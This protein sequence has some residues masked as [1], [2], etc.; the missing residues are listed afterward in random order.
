[1]VFKLVRIDSPSP[2]KIPLAIGTHV[3]GR[4]KFLHNDDTDKRVSRNHAELEVTT[5]SVNLK[6]LHQNPCF[7]IKKS[8]ETHLLQQDS[9]VLLCHGDKFGLLPDHFWYEVLHCPDP[10]TPSP[11]TPD[12]TD[13]DIHNGEEA[14]INWNE[15]VEEQDNV[16]PENGSTAEEEVLRFS[17]EQP[18][19]FEQ[20]SE[21]VNGTRSASPSLLIAPEPDQPTDV[22]TTSN[23][24]DIA[25]P[26]PDL[27][28]STDTEDYKVPINLPAVGT[29]SPAKRDHSPNDTSPV[30]LKRVKNERVSDGDAAGPS[31]DQPSSN[32]DTKPNVA[33]PAQPKPRLRERCL[34][35]ENCY[36]RNPQHLSEFSHPRDADWGAGSRGTCPYGAACRRRDPRHWAAHDHPPGTQPPHARPGNKRK[37]RQRQDS[38]SDDEERLDNLIVTGKRVRKPIQR[39]SWSSA[40]SASDED[41]YKTDES[42]EWQPDSN[43]TNSQDYSQDL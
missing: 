31:N 32:T 22:P 25:P 29:R 18:L 3:I 21:E 26:T 24:P 5:D 43:V 36:R 10:D 13:K 16:P 40:E 35:G 39:A 2:C 9:T 23:L 30:D 34:Y 11:A 41:P 38:V 12:T 42:D 8:V 17:E 37:R 27:P 7:Y 14:V 15:E 28:D 6:S 19:V 33:S 4:G 20:N 1:M